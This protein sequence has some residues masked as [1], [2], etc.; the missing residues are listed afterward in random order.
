MLADA[1]ACW[2]A[3]AHIEA[4]DAGQDC[5]SALVS[6]Q[7]KLS[8]TTDIILNTTPTPAFNSSPVAHEGCSDIQEDKRRRLRLQKKKVEM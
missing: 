6:K 4:S 8:D 1:L 7:E 5:I 3:P 2:E